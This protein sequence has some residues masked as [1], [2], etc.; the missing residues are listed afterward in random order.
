MKAALLIL[1]FEESV[2][3]EKF[4]Q[5]KTITKKYHKLAMVHHPDR[6]GGNGELFKEIS[7]AY[8]LLGEY[9]EEHRDD[10][11]EGDFDFEEEVARK[12]FH[13]FEFSKVKENMR[14][15]TIHIQN[16][17]SV[18]WEKVLSKHYG[19]PLDRKG[20]GLHWKV[21]NYTDGNAISNITISKWH[22]PKKDNQSKLHVQSNESGN[23]LPAH[24]VDNVL[25]K[26]F[27][28]VHTYH[29]T[30]L[31]HPSHVPSANKKVQA[32]E[33]GFKCKG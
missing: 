28:E 19:V 25:P 6:P 5:L 9:L 12:T 11:K 24:F 15:F 23:F 29:P 33:L 8:L 26:L 17:H 21:E 27:E 2:Q 13:Q 31:Q 22:I 16:N 3:A 20:N 10:E 1:G 18:I 30:I 14:S 7:A 32:K 4:P